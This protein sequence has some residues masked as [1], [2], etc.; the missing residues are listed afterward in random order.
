VRRRGSA[1]VPYTLLGVNPP[2]DLAFK[3]KRS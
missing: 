3:E 2:R 1:V